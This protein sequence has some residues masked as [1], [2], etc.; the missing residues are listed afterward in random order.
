MF[1]FQR[2]RV[3]TCECETLLP[4]LGPLPQMSHVD[5]IAVLLESYKPIA[6]RA[7]QAQRVSRGGGIEPI[8]GSALYRAL[9]FTR[10]IWRGRRSTS[11]VLARE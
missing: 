1:G 6:V 10:E 2:R 8:R 3:F 5:A 4:K 7:Q 11:D 9:A